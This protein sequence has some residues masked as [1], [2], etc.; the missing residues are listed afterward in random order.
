MSVGLPIDLSEFRDRPSDPA[1]LRAV[2][3]VIM[4]RLRADVAELRG[5]AAPNGDLF[6]WRR[7]R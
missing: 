2:T 3:D 7:S 5:E 1:T 6:V 4:R